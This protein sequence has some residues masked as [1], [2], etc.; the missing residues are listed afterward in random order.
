MLLFVFLNIFFDIVYIFIT[1]RA[2]LTYLP[3]NKLHPFIKPV[4]VTTEPILGVIRRGLPPESMGFDASAFIALL[5]IFIIQQTIYSI[6]PLII[7][8]FIK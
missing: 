8:I 4:Y 5:M 7:Q 3:H 2:F 1:I 6:I